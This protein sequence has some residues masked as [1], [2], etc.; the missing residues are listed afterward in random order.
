MIKQEYFFRALI[1]IKNG[2]CI[3]AFKALQLNTLKQRLLRRGVNHY[4][5]KIK[6]K[7][8]KALKERYIKYKN[9]ARNG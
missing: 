5:R 6:R 7:S 3:G 2:I 9:A 8:F 4:L 1:D